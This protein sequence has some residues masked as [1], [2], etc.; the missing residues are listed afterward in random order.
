MRGN[1]VRRALMCVLAALSTDIAAADPDLAAFPP[2]GR[3]VQ[4]DGRQMHISCIGSGAPTVVLEDGQGGASLDWT[5]VRRTVGKT[6]RP[7][8]YDR[9]GYG[10]SDPS[11]APMD[12]KETSRQLAA[13]LA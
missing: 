10:W 9:P 13:L 2:P 4:V 6:T 8:A 1:F 3:L 12:A 7:C 11:D 5:W